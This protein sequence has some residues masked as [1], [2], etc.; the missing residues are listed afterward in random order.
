MSAPNDTAVSIIR[1]L[2]LPPFWRDRA[3]AAGIHLL[4]SMLVAV[5]AGVLVFAI[6]YPYPYR[7][8]AGGRDLFILIVTV[9][10]VLG[11]AIT[12][13]IFDRRKR[14]PVL[15]RDLAVVGLLQLAALAYGL[16]TMSLARPVQLVFEFDRFRVV[17]AV[18]VPEELLDKTPDG[19]NAK[20]LLGPGLLAV[21]PFRSEGEKM[22]ANLSALGGVQQAFRP[23]FWQTYA[24][25]A[26]RVGQAAKPLEELK[27]RFPQRQSDIEAAVKST[28]RS[29]DQLA[30]LPL[31]ARKTFW[32]V[33]LDRQSAQVLAYI[34]L[35]PY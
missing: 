2:A 17:H 7:E 30:Y 28:G 29:T 27:R 6:W 19:I 3:W 10:V 32:T 26:I 9:D 31:A 21:R 11:P 34:P 8:I 15:R 20:P 33:L 22:E 5:L 16:W 25:A 4:L 13:A 35:D 1:T 12:F 24:E 23:D 18:D 14:M